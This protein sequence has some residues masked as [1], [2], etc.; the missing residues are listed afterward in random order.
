MFI[1]SIL[2]KQHRQ[3]ASAS[4]QMLNQASLAGPT[5]LQARYFAA[6][7]QQT[8]E[9]VKEEWGEKYSDECFKFEKEWKLISEKIE[10]E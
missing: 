4:L 6:P 3:L 9:E 2:K 1:S 8:P 10:N 7:A 5:Q